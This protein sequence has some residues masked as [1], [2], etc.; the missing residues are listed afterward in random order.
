MLYDE[1]GRTYVEPALLPEEDHLFWIVSDYRRMYKEN[2]R[3]TIRNRKLMETIGQLNG[4]QFAQSRII[5]E[6]KRM[7]DRLIAMLKARG[8]D[9]PNDIRDFRATKYEARKH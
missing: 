8:I 7:M 6:Q 5:G 9:I 1:E 2:C 3:L 4:L